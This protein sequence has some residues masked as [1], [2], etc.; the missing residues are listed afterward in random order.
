MEDERA[1][2]DDK[3]GEAV[4]NYLVR[5]NVN[6]GIM[7]T[8]KWGC[9]KT[10]YW[11]NVLE[12][13]IKAKDLFPLYVSVNGLTSSE[14]VA[15][16]ILMGLAKVKSKG[17]VSEKVTTVL[18][19]IAAV[20]NTVMDYIGTACEAVKKAVG[21]GTDLLNVDLKAD[22]ILDIFDFSGYVIC[23]D[24]VE[25]Y[26]G[27]MEELMGFCNNLLEHRKAHLVFIANEEK[28]GDRFRTLKEKV[29]GK[30]VHCNLAP[31][32]IVWILLD[33]AREMNPHAIDVMKENIDVILDVL[34]WSG[35][36]NYRTVK[37]LI[38]DF[39]E[40]YEKMERLSYTDEELRIA[41]RALLK[42]TMA[43]GIEILA[44]GTPLEEIEELRDPSCAGLRKLVPAVGGKDRLKQSYVSL[45]KSRYYK[46]YPLEREFG[47]H[48]GIY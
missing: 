24:D 2:L 13:R 39:Q 18:E 45:F 15:R 33:Q 37:V 5:K 22:C 35:E 34:F 11:K 21:L 26:G 41:E 28:M 7:L 27:E 43:A 8:G 16:K 36:R 29:I 1:V 9:G 14:A 4:L 12:P 3:V 31:Y 6:H 10:F 44:K 38:G 47:H 42:F 48:Y 30:T 40:L 23:I 46:G 32:N 25:R 17:I 19:N 20:A